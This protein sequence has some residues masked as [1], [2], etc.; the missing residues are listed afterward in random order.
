MSPL[1]CKLLLRYVTRHIHCT[2]LSSKVRLTWEMLMFYFIF[3]S[4]NSDEF[5]FI[6]I[7]L[8]LRKGTLLV[9]SSSFSRT[10]LLRFS[11]SAFS[12]NQVKGSICYNIFL[13]FLQFFQPF[14]CSLLLCIC[15]GLLSQISFISPCSPAPLKP[16][17]FCWRFIIQ[18]LIISNNRK[19]S[20]NMSALSYWVGT[21]STSP[22]PSTGLFIIFSKT[23]FTSFRV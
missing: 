19:I 17:W 7:E 20:T 1:G 8:L 18:E 14:S 4:T 5:V 12:C 15:I 16:V 11:V 21:I 6:F 3:F 23:L 13:C 9:R 22:L 10:T 2:P